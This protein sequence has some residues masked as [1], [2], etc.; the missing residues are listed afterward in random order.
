MTVHRQRSSVN[1]PRPH[2]NHHNNQQPTTNNQPPTTNNKQ[3]TTNNKPPPT[4]NQQTNK[5]TTNPINPTNPTENFFARL[6][7]SAGYPFVICYFVGLKFGAPL[8]RVSQKFGA[9]FWRISLAHTAFRFNSLKF[10]LTYKTH[11]DLEEFKEH[12]FKKVTGDEALELCS[13]ER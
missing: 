5:P 4:N 1:D 8:V 3:Q 7:L 13:R 11:L 12:M 6:R 9:P 2:H 10:F